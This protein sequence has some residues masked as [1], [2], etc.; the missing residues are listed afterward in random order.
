MTS[1]KCLERTKA[2]GILIDVQD[3]F[4]R[5]HPDRERLI[6]GSAAFAN[7]LNYLHIPVVATLERPVAVKGKLPEQIFP[8]EGEILEKDFF[9][10]TQEQAIA[11]HLESL[12]CKQIVISGSETD[13]C[14]LQSC[15]GLLRLGYEV[16][17]V[18]DLLFSS[19]QNVQSAI[20]RMRASGATFMSLK[21][22]FHELVRSVE[23]SPYRKSLDAEYGPLPEMLRGF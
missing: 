22:L 10:L 19:A 16:F 6:T 3:Y 23:G 13:V 4:L 11:A 1:V 2:A 15:L 14:V 21:T 5:G 18:E 8:F 17:V 20:D 9:D 12:G 7:L